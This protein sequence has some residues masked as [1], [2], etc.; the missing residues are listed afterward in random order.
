MDS[1]IHADYCSTHQAPPRTLTPNQTFGPATLASMQNF[2]QNP[3]H[4]NGMATNSGVQ[5]T[6]VNFDGKC[7]NI[8]GV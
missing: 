6:L 8:G 1:V 7:M 4:S 3:F 5:L 2:A